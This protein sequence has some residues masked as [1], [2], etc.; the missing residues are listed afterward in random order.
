MTPNELLEEVKLRFTPL[1]HD[2]PDKLQALLI[3]ALRTFQD[4]AGVMKR[5]RITDPGSKEIAPP[6]DY[7][8][9]VS[10]TDNTGDMVYSDDFG[11]VIALEFNFSTRFPVTLIYLASLTGLDLV[12]DELPEDI[13][14][15]VSDYLEALI[16]IPNTQRHRRVSIAGKLDV[17]DLPDENTLNQRKLELE[18]QMSSRRAVIPGATVYSSSFKAG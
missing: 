2:E 12:K 11:G 1:M 3:K 16:A 13:I 18:E 15:I 4:R 5:L 10:V 14:G 6:D 7:L 17:S 8:T 9:L